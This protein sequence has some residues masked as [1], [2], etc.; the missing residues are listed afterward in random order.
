M[1]SNALGAALLAGS[2]TPATFA[3]LPIIGCCNDYTAGDV[4]TPFLDFAT[5]LGVPAI[6]TDVVHDGSG[7][8]PALIAALLAYSKFFTGFP[9]VG[10]FLNADNSAAVLCGPIITLSSPL[11]KSTPEKSIALAQATRCFR[12]N[13]KLGYATQAVWPVVNEDLD[14]LQRPPIYLDQFTVF[15]ADGVQL[16]QYRNGKDT[17]YTAGDYASM[18]YW[19]ILQ[20][21]W[22]HGDWTLAST[23]NLWQGLPLSSLAASILGLQALQSQGHGLLTR[24]FLSNLLPLLLVYD[25]TGGGSFEFT[26]SP[27]VSTLFNNDFIGVNGDRTH[28]L[29]YV[30]P[31]D[32]EVYDLVVQ[33]FGNVAGATSVSV[34]ISPGGISVYL[35]T[36][37]PSGI[38]ATITG[39][40]GHDTTNVAQV[41]RGDVL[42]IR[43]LAAAD[44]ICNGFSATLQFRPRL[45]TVLGVTV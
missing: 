10:P 16:A 34:V 32:G 11:I 28:F 7:A 20:A 19:Q 30:V 36:Y 35:P 4:P 5:N 25:Y 18:P 15:G 27:A 2:T 39:A 21:V 24:Q 12:R 6:V 38:S 42:G 22:Q 13:N 1:L 8:T 17:T 40:K 41:N 23:A 44:W 3:G 33:G 37:T 43:I 9:L 31:C 45:K 26:I 29:P 14:R